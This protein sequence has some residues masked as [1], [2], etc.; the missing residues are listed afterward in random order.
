MSIYIKLVIRI[1]LILSCILLLVIQIH[2]ISEGELIYL[3]S[4]QN[5]VEAV[6]KCIARGDDV[7]SKCPRA[8]RDNV[9]SQ[10]F[11]VPIGVRLFPKGA[12]PLHIAALYGNLSVAQVLLHQHP[13]VD[14]VLPNDGRTPLHLALEMESDAMVKLLVSSG[15]DPNVYGPQSDSAIF[16]VLLN[17]RI[18]MLKL[19]I[20]A[21][22]D[23]NVRRHS[24]N[25]TPLDIANETNQSDVIKVLQE[26][27]QYRKN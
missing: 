4:A 10:Y 3:A 25:K 13:D 26:T 1:S 24:D 21:G 27:S 12:T 20:Q 14:P 15:A 7:N 18:R 22:A 11:C 19:L 6:N 16:E 5:D 23:I 9:Y 2:H 17:S 8:I